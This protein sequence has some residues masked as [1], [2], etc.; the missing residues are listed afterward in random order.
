MKKIASHQG[1][2]LLPDNSAGGAGVAGIALTTSGA[3]VASHSNVGGAAQAQAQAD[4][5]AAGGA[6]AAG[7]ALAAGG[8]GVA[9]RSNVGD[10]AK[11][12]ADQA[13]AGGAGSA[14]RSNGDG[15]LVHGV[16]VHAAGGAGVASRF[17]VDGAA[18]AQ[19]DQIAAGGVG[20]AGGFNVDGAA[21]A[22]VRL[23]LPCPVLA[24]LQ[25]KLE[26]VSRRRF[27][28]VVRSSGEPH[29]WAER[30]NVLFQDFLF[31]LVFQ[32]VIFQSVRVISILFC[33]C[34]TPMILLAS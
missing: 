4:Q 5:A 24:W 8:A 10:E 1:K 29:Q 11:T 7:I 13:A 33:R 31:I 6:G 34:H 18:Q 30:P 17:N 20:V 22:Q 21:Q 9:S 19:E 15:E 26:V 25:R 2:H 27:L 23:G 14:S 28:T 16:H 3:G 32:S 12:Q